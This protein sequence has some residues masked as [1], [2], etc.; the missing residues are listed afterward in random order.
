MIRDHVGNPQ[1]L[2]ICLDDVVNDRALAMTSSFSNMVIFGQ[3]LRSL[4]NP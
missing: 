1:A 3:K 4:H 2:S